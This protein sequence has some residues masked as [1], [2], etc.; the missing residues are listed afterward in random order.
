MFARLPLYLRLVRMDKPIGSLLLLWPTLNALWIASDG[1]PSLSLLVIFALGTILMRSAGCAINDYADRDFDRYVKRTE[2]RPITSGKIKAWEAVALAA[3][4]SLIAFLLILPLNAL[5]KELS[6]AA[7]FVAGTYPFTKRF[8][9]IPQAYLGIAF[10][11]GIPMA[12]AAIQNQVPPLA[13]VMLI[14]NVFWSVAY[15]TEYAMVDRDDDIKIGIRTSALTFGRFDVLAIML[16]YAVTLGI[17]VGIGVV[18]SFGV[19][20]WIGLAAAAGCAVYHYTLIKDRE[21]MP[22]FAAFRHNNWLGGAL[23]A[24]IAAHYAAQAF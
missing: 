16:C 20:Y 5:T 15:D 1:H 14:A 11:F 22:C 4:L 2:N 7:L 18:L 3:G 8:F 10:G 9:A 6:V 19:L 12:F 24:G 13:W 17:Y 23:F 21:R